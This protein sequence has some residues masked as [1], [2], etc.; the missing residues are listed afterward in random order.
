MREARLLLS[1]IAIQQKQQAEAEERLEQVL[2]EFPDDSSAANDLGYLWAERGVHLERALRLI[3]LAVKD[4][5][6]NIAYRD[7]LG[8]V[9]YQTGQYPKA[10]AELEKAAKGEK[11]DAVI[12]DHLGDAYWKANQAEKA[13]QAWQR[14]V[15]VFRQ[16]KDEEKAKGVEGKLQ[17]QRPGT[18]H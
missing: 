12:L 5:P 3:E 10:V 11:P 15:K 9:Y 18:K 16:E 4:E 13:R 2:D 1:N 17:K 6:E 14:A 8:W 7:S